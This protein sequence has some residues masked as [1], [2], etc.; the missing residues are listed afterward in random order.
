MES[1]SDM[2]NLKIWKE[3]LPIDL[4]EAMSLSIVARD[5]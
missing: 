2:E 1:A 5:V 4:F 3:S